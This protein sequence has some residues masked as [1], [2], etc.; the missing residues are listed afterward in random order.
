MRICMRLSTVHLWDC[1]SKYSFRIQHATRYGR[2]FTFV[3]TFFGQTRSSGGITISGWMAELLKNS[4]YFL[5][6]YQNILMGAALQMASRSQCCGCPT[7]N[8]N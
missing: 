1:K 4:Q 3:A 5:K 7:K 8:E 6:D 2:S